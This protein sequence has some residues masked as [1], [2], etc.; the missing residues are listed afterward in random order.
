MILRARELDCLELLPAYD[1]L[2]KEVH[3]YGT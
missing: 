2:N 3:L 1:I